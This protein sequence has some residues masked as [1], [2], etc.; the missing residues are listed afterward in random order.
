MP[1]VISVG[2]RVLPISWVDYNGKVLK[3]TR[4]FYFVQQINGDRAVLV[5]D[6]MKGAVYAAINTKN[7]R[8]V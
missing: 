2:T 3:K 5:A 4:N 6:S 8:I 1:T 7:L